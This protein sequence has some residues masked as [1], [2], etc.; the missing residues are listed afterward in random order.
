MNKMGGLN[1]A[2]LFWQD[3]AGHPELRRL[4]F[5]GRDL[6]HA[7]GVAD[8]IGGVLLALRSLWHDR[9]IA[10]VDQERTDFSGCRKFK[11][12][13]SLYDLHSSSGEGVEVQGRLPAEWCP[14][15]E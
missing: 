11:T 9:I 5:A 3:R 14:K 12:V 6:H 7:H 8:H 2:T 10:H 1:V 15:L 13:V 4:N